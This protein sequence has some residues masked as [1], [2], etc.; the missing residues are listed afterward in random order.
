MEFL[1][2]NLQSYIDNHSRPEPELLQKLNRETHLKVPMPQMIAGHLQGQVIRI[3][4]LIHKPKY[5]LEIG[6]YTGYSGICLAEGLT[7]G[8]K[9]YSIEID[10]E[11]EDMINRY[12]SEANILDKTE[13]IIGN[14]VE[15]IPKIPHE[16]D[17]VFI[18]A[19]KINYPNYYDL[20]IDKMAIGGLILGDNVLW[21]GKV[22]NPEKNDKDTLA[23]REFNQKI[24]NDS[25]VENVLIPVRDGLMV[26]RKIA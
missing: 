17:L 7:E 4:S 18:D 6:S 25:R 11:K 8:G 5:A 14:A 23:I 21:S 2:E 19:D 20:V 24:Q 15:E 26:A 3:L 10:P 16:L 13:L 22:A 12:W 9:L 1:P